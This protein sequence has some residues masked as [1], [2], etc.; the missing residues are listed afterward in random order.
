MF[1]EGASVLADDLARVS[2]SDLWI[3]PSLTASHLYACIQVGP[4][5]GISACIP[6]EPTHMCSHGRMWWR[7]A[8]LRA[9]RASLE[10]N[11][12]TTTQRL[13]EE[14]R[15]LSGGIRIGR[16]PVPHDGAPSEARKTELRRIGFF[17]AQRFEKGA[18]LL[19]A[20]IP[21]LLLDGYEVVLHDSAGLVRAEAMQGLTVLG[22]VPALADEIAKCDLVVVPYDATRYRIRAS[23]ILWDCIA[24]GVPTIVPADTDIG[25]QVQ[26]AGTGKTFSSFSTVEVHRSIAEARRD[27]REL[28]NAAFE[29]SRRWRNTEGANR[30]VAALVGDGSVSTRAI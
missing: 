28:A 19:P 20:L 2:D 8:F 30:F 23:A 5:V 26:S 16:F 9:E 18:E 10:L 24:S 13:A 22:Y 6:E 12:G 17:G 14:F 15:S 27:Y 3:W 25:L 4:K 7:Y 29:E 11:L 1:L 21:R